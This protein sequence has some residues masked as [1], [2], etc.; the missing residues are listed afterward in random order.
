MGMQFDCRDESGQPLTSRRGTL[1]AHAPSTPNPGG[2]PDPI[3]WLTPA[4]EIAPGSWRVDRNARVV[5]VPNSFTLMV[6]F[7][8]FEGI[9]FNPETV[10]YTDGATVPLV[11][12]R[13]RMPAPTVPTGHH[14]LRWSEL[15]GRRLPTDDEIVLSTRPMAGSFFELESSAEVDWW[16]EVHLVHPPSLTS[17]RVARTDGPSQNR[18]GS[19]YHRSFASPAPVVPVLLPNGSWDYEIRYFTGLLLL[20]YKPRFL[21]TPTPVYELDMNDAPY[22]VRARPENSLA[23]HFLWRKQ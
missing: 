14:R 3:P 23:L 21:G 1:I 17:A 19:P 6:S 16:K 10:T 2:I 18:I 9:V 8:S 12:R 7:P 4:L 22:R 20:L 11:F 5:V 15:D 13:L